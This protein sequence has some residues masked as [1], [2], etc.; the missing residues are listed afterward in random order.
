VRFPRDE[1]RAPVVPPEGQVRRCIATD[2]AHTPALNSGGS[3]AW[4]HCP[5]FFVTEPAS[6]DETWRFAFCT[7]CR[8]IIGLPKAEA[9][10]LEE[11]GRRAHWMAP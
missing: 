2:G 3:L 8:C 9:D 5:D 7:A 1:R 6:G 11:A 10:A 4:V